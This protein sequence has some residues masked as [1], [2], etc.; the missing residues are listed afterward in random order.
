[1]TYKK[2]IHVPKTGKHYVVSVFDDRIPNGFAKRNVR[3]TLTLPG[4]TYTSIMVLIILFAVK[5]T[6]TKLKEQEK[7]CTSVKVYVAGE[8]GHVLDADVFNEIDMQDFDNPIVAEIHKRQHENE[9]S[10][11]LLKEVGRAKVKA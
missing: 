6:Y 3:A 10:I 2:P 11:K 4:L 5:Q 9:A 8:D 1:M 7:H